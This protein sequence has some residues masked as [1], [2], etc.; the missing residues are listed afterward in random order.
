[1]AGAGQVGTGAEA[2]DSVGVGELSIVSVGV[3]GLSIVSVRAGGLSMVSVGAGGFSIVSV[4]AG[5]LS[6][7]SVGAGGL[8]IVSVGAGGF[9]IVSVSAEEF[10]VGFSTTGEEETATASADSVELS[11]FSALS[12]SGFSIVSGGFSTFFSGVSA[13]V[14]DSGVGLSTV[15]TVS[16]ADV[17]AACS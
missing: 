12:T 3:G 15:F 17:L 8:S 1:M 5:G 6:I 16:G 2:V 14:V 10:G 7:V 13:P 4:R 11:D 9:S